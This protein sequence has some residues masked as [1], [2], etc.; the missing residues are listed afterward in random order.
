MARINAGSTLANQ[1][2]PPFVV[3]D[4]VATGWELQWNADILAFEAYDPSGNVVETGFDSIEVAWFP[5]VTQQVFVVP[6]ETDTKQS[7]I[8]TIQ[9]VKQ[10]QTAYTYSSDSASGTTTVTLSDSVIVEDVEILGLQTSG[11]ASTQIYGPVPADLDVTGIAQTDFDLGWLA[12]SVQS[13]IVTIDGV[14]QATNAYGI[15][16]NGTAT[17][18][19]LSFTASPVMTV[20]A[21]AL[22][23][24]GTGHALNDVLTVNSGGG[25]GTQAEF[26]VTSETGGVIDPGGISITNAGA[27]TTFPTGTVTTSTSGSGINATFNLTKDSQQIEVVGILTA[28]ETPASPVDVINLAGGVGAPGAPD[29]GH[30]RLFSSKTLSADQQLLNFRD[31]FEG[32]N[33]TIT[34]GAS[35][36]TIAAAQ[37]TFGQVGAAV[38]LVNIP[39]SGTDVDFR[40]IAASGDR[41]IVTSDGDSI[42]IDYNLGYQDVLDGT[43]LDPYVQLST[44]KLIAFTVLTTPHGVTLLDPSAVPVGD[45]VTVKNQTADTSAIT[46]TPAAGQIQAA[47]NGIL[48]ATHVLSG[49]LAYV[50]FYSDGSDYYIISE[51]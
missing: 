10:Q 3:A 33:I 26:T 25:V 20:S 2:A 4:S 13:L 41:T 36:I 37:S 39:G 21:A 51:G 17:D 28:G 40:R 15:T 45:T 18:T 16:P 50:T 31:L 42:T 5:N 11:G 14:K 32:S 22:V 47:S 43:D 6:W 7:L 38:N 44:D 8:I 34:E 35:S 24:F 19:T 48:G 12:P 23:N 27:Y 46:I 9:G 1:Y 30:A 29:A 49:A